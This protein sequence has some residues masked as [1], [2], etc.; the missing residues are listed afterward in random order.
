PVRAPLHF[1]CFCIF[2]ATALSFAFDFSFPEPGAIPAPARRIVQFP[3]GW[4][5]LAR[6]ILHFL[7]DGALPRVEFCNSRAMELSSAWDSTFSERWSSP[8]REIPHFPSGGPL[9]RVGFYIFCAMDLS[10]VGDSAIPER[11]TSQA[12]GRRQ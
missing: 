9:Q 1:L 12:D 7:S 3:N 4:T 5:T 8:A 6:G 11:W 10:C 2:C